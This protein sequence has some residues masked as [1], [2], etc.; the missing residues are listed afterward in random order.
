MLEAL[1]HQNFAGKPL[2]VLSTSPE[3]LAGERGGNKT[4]GGGATMGQTQYHVVPITHWDREWYLS[5]EEF[6]VKLVEMVDRLIPLLET[7]PAFKNF[8]LDGQTS[9]VDDYLE[10]RPEMRERLGELIRQ[11]RID[12]GP[13]YILPDEFLVSAES[14][15][16][17][18]LLG[19]KMAHALGGCMQIGYLPDS[20]CHIAQMPAILRGFG[21][22][23]AVVWRGI[24][25]EPGEEKCEFAWEAP[26][27]DRVLL[28]HLPTG[29]YG[30]NPITSPSPSE[31][32]QQFA[33]QREACEPR[34]VTGEC[35]WT[36][37]ADHYDAHP[38]LPQHVATLHAQFD[39]VGVQMSRLQDF[40]AQVQARLTLSDCP[41]A[42]GELR[43]GYGWAFNL[44]GGVYS[45][46]MYLKQANWQAQLQLERYLSPLNA[47][48][49]QAGKPSRKALIDH[50]RKLLLQNHPHDSICGCSIDEVHDEM[51]TRFR[52]VDNLTRQLSATLCDELIPTDGACRRDDTSLLLFN[53]SPFERRSVVETEVAF[54]LAS[55]KDGSFAHHQS[56]A[57]ECHFSLL[58]E[59]GSSVPF[60][61][62]GRRED[63]DEERPWGVSPIQIWSQKVR[64]RLR[65]PPVPA[66]SWCQL[67]VVPQAETPTLWSQPH[68]TASGN[69]ISNAHVRVE[70]Q[71]D[72]TFEITDLDLGRTFRGQHVL[73]DG[74]DVGDEY[75]YSPP[76]KDL[77]HNSTDSTA[78]VSGVAV[79]EGKLKQQLIVTGGMPL[80]VGVHDSRK[81]RSRELVNLDYTTTIELHADSSYVEFRTRIDNRSRDHRLRVRFSTGVESRNHFA[82]SPFA[83]VER[84]PQRQ[85]P[86]RYVRELPA[87]VAP[88]QKLMLAADDRLGVALFSEGLPE[89][90]WSPDGEVRLTL[91]RCVDAL[92]RHDLATRAGGAAGHLNGRSTEGAQCI[93]SHDFRYGLRWFP[94]PWQEAWNEVARDAERFHLPFLLLRRKGKTPCTL[95]PS[96]VEVQPAG[97]FLSTYKEAEDLKG[98]LVRLYNPTPDSRSAQLRF[99]QAPSKIE[100]L[101][102]DETEAV[103][104]EFEGRELPLE[105]AGSEIVTL[106]LQY[107]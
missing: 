1:A 17:N 15:V 90:E 50:G 32:L 60:E 92:D 33:K 24:G 63:F 3:L 42:Q 46:R 103:P 25:G 43:F 95:P 105:F 82:H 107:S 11:G 75:N 39:D 38:L 74:G 66:L 2:G 36:S 34:S 86:D 94:A 4:A 37:G 83:L 98:I 70:A 44:T 26:S 40:F 88:M 49:R 102:L 71:L 9:A 57:E 64:V 12:I 101:R 78:F 21:I 8:L 62:L 10:I 47:L 79:R 104:L 97:I 76:E 96:G 59:D 51:M 48:I 65:T 41:T 56:P 99:A 55:L 27:G 68:L 87:T 54:H 67:R 7:D 100:R 85:D 6:R 58:A 5:Y 89:Y 93:G 20:F 18:L 77:L 13:W 23:T 73:E 106:R 22:E 19:R 72:G 30:H 35:L 69:S 31:L 52:K 80:P 61:I 53:P 91:L 84:G 28:H 16:E 14:T 45:S 29:G 81:R